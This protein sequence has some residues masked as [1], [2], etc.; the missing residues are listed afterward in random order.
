MLLH[1]PRASRPSGL[2]APSKPAQ[3]SLPAPGVECAVARPELSF[4]VLTNHS[5]LSSIKQQSLDSALSLRVRKPARAQRAGLP[6]YTRLRPRLGRL[7]AAETQATGGWNHLESLAPGL[8]QREGWVGDGGRY[9]WS[10]H[11]APAAWGQ[12]FQ[13]S[14]L[15]SASPRIQVESSDLLFLLILQMVRRSLRSARIQG[16]GYRGSGGPRSHGRRACGVG[17]GVLRDYV[18][19]RATPHP[20]APCLRKPRLLLPGSP[21]YS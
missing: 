18:W 2:P 12:G 17:E 21:P 5:K 10:L 8:G 1:P 15:R 19:K 16:R 4:A 6:L 20:S 14:T 9:T 3:G 11:G 7:K 13:S